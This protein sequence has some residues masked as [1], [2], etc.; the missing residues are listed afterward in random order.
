MSL[1][2]RNQ[3]DFLDKFIM[4]VSREVIN[5]YN[6]DLKINSKQNV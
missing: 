3:T 5:V 1:K 2:I 4:N 6:L